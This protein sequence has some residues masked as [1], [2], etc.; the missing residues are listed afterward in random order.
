MINARMAGILYFLGTAFGI[1]S[2]VIGGDVIASLIKTVPLDHLNLDTLYSSRLLGAALFTLLMGI[3]LVAM[4]AFLYPIF[5]ML[6]AQLEPSVFLLAPRAYMLHFIA[7]DSSH[8]GSPFGDSSASF[9][10]WSTPSCTFSI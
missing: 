3:S 9:P 6:L 10:I 8:V 2:V 1:M 4:T 7:R 5:K